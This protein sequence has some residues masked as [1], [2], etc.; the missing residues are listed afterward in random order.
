M[1][2]PRVVIDTNVLVAALRSNQGASFRLISLIPHGKFEINLSVPLALEYEEA[3]L[4]L[5]GQ[6]PLSASDVRDIIGYLCKVA[7]QWPIYFLWR[8]LLRD[9]EDE[10]VLELAVASNSEFIVT[11]NIRDFTPARQ[12]GVKVCTPKQ[13]LESIGELP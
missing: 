7:H 4:N 10:M 6:V 13:F 3:A 9:P 2:G 8:P 11:F 5:V 1:A 12:F